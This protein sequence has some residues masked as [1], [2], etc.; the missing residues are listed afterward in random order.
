MVEPARWLSYAIAYRPAA[1]RTRRREEPEA[2]AISAVLTEDTTGSPSAASTAA[3]MSLGAL[4]GQNA[5][6]GLHSPQ[7]GCPT[8]PRPRVLWC[9]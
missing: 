8:R 4:V 7:P 3:W 2:F 5:D 1:T 9:P 6:H